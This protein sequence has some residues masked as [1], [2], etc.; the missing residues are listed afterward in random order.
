MCPS[1]DFP[2]LCAKIGPQ[3]AAPF[4]T[5]SG[6]GRIVI[7]LLTYGRLRVRSATVFAMSLNEDTTAAKAWHDMHGTMNDERSHWDRH[8]QNQTGSL[9]VERRRFWF[10]NTKAGFSEL[11][12]WI[13]TCMP[14]RLVNAAPGPKH[15]ALERAL[16]AHPPSTRHKSSQ[17][18]GT[19][20]KTDQVDAAVQAQRGPAFVVPPDAPVHKNQ[21]ERKGF[22]SSEPRCSRIARGS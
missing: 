3:H 5:C 12:R 2:W 8:F 1:Y 21:Y 7:G 14:E 20:A 4:L 16:A 18:S 6:D 17:T 19:R 22:R 10:A 13:G 9:S 15:R 11:C